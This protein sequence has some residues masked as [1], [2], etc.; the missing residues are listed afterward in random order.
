MKKGTQIL[1][2]GKEARYLVKA[3]KEIFHTKEGGFDLSK[4]KNFG[5]KLTTSKGIEFTAVEPRFFDLVKKI[6]RGPQIILPK[7]AGLIITETGIGPGD[8]VIDAGT[9]TGWMSA[10]LSNVVGEKG[11][12]TTYEKSKANHKLAKENFKKLK[13]KNIRAKHGDAYKDIKEKKQDLVVLDLSEPHKVKNLKKILKPGAYC[14]AYLPQVSQVQEFIKFANKNN[15]L[16]ERTVELQEREWHFEG[17]IS[18]PKSQSIGHT[19]FLVFIRNI[20]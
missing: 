16:V 2:L 14:V 18:R 8:K 13:L 17:R 10:F 3:R 1:L 5:D 6:K 20:A 11:R 12:V 15:F 7:D 4:I 9:G 19:A